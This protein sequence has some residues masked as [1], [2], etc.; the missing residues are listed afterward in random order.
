MNEDLNFNV[1]SLIVNVIVVPIIAYMANKLK[2]ERAAAKQQL[3][4][5]REA[6][7]DLLARVVKVEVQVSVFWKDVSFDAARTLHKPHPEARPMDMLLECYMQGVITGEQ[8][9]ELKERLR[10][11]IQCEDADKG[12]RTAASMMLRSIEQLHPTKTGGLA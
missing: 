10:Q 3:D 7:D 12:E 5:M 11:K 4:H 8:I 6:I 1:V 9:I 2:D